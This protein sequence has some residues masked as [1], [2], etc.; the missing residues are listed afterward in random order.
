M[1]DWR[2]TS[3]LLLTSFL[4][5]YCSRALA[6]THP[7]CAAVDLGG[8]PTGVPIS[9]NLQFAREALSRTKA[10]GRVAAV[11]RLLAPP[12]SLLL[13][14]QSMPLGVGP[15]EWFLKESLGCN[16]LS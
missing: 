15:K 1:V 2:S 13:Y 12:P 3:R 5:T 14:T 6:E 10:L 9:N 16:P 4:I 11:F 8:S 7:C